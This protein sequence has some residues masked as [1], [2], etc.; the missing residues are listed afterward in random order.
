MLDVVHSLPAWSQLGDDEQA[1]IDG[2]LAQIGGDPDQ[3]RAMGDLPVEDQLDMLRQAAAVA[4]TMQ[5]S[6]VASDGGA[7]YESGV[8]ADPV[9]ADGGGAP[10]YAPADAPD[11]SA[12]D[13]GGG[14]GGDGGGGGGVPADVPDPSAAD[15]G[16]APTD[17]Q[18]DQVQQQAD[19]EADDA[20]RLM[21][22]PLFAQMRRSGLIGAS[23]TNAAAKVKSARAAGQRAIAVGQRAIKAGNK[24]GAAVVAAGKRAIDASSRLAAVVSARVLP[25]A[26]TRQ[27]QQPQLHLPKSDAQQVQ[28]QRQAARQSVPQQHA[29]QN[30]SHVR[31]RGLHLLGASPSLAESAQEEA[32]TISAKVSPWL[33]TF[34]LAAFGLAVL[35]RYQIADAVGG[36]VFGSFAGLRAALRR[37]RVA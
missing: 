9:A 20:D 21:L 13:G 35:N 18:L 10:A 34:S 12:G 16:G 32:K 7:A 1:V 17:A 33:W 28:R 3:I 31:I 37:K 36:R 19:G 4:T 24:R 22:T 11:P 27:A 25:G 23:L 2:L 30:M 14:G 15:G 8:P 26:G 29:Q 5:A 6:D